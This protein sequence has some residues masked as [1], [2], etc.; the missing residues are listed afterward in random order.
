MSAVETLFPWQITAWQHVQRQIKQSRLPHALLLTGIQGIG[1][2]HFAYL[3][4]RSLLCE[5][6]GSDGFPCGSCRSCQW[7]IAGSHPDWLTVSPQED[8]EVIKIDQV[9]ELIEKLT[10]SANRPGGYKIVNI[11]PAESMNAHAANAFLKT[12]EEPVKNTLILLTTHRPMALPATLRSRC[13]WVYFSVPDKTVVLEWLQKI[14][15]YHPAIETILSLVG[16]APLKAK[17]WIENDEMSFR[18]EIFQQWILW[19]TGKMSL[20]QLSEKWGKQDF[21]RILLH[22]FSWIE[23]AIRWGVVEPVSSN[24]INRDFIHPLS[25]LAVQKTP[26]KLFR[27]YDKLLQ[28]KKGWESSLHW[29]QQLLIED[30]LLSWAM[31]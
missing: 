3:L 7:V 4:S 14:E 2:Q 24:V 13:Q 26:A 28:V 30:L 1:K 22:L 9:R 25:V 20:V 8:S 31:L 5:H 29:N 23:D 11:D 21:S 12:L 10:R 19:M 27:F 16:Y 6:P 15:K 17:E 18:N